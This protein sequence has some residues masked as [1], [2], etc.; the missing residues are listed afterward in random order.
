MITEKND[1]SLERNV[2]HY[3]KDKTYNWNL[4][5]YNLN[6]MLKLNI[7]CIG[8]ALL[9]LILNALTANRI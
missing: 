9:L 1:L 6:G 8:Y 4:L 3:F 5:L 7:R 2:S